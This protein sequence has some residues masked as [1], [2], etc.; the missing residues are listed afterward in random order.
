MRIR[1]SSSVP[2]G[3]F[4]FP[5]LASPRFSINERTPPTSFCAWD[6]RAKNLSLMGGSKIMFSTSPLYVMLTHHILLPQLSFN[7]CLSRKIHQSSLWWPCPSSP[8]VGAGTGQ[9]QGQWLALRFSAPAVPLSRHRVWV[10]L[11]TALLQLL[12][13]RV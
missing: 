3:S 8:A 4:A 7:L 2:G 5:D 10:L 11:L 12:L 9:V 13:L 1:V 6:K